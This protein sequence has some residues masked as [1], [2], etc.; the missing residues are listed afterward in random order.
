[1]SGVKCT[2]NS[3]KCL[4]VALVCVLAFSLVGCGS[5]KVDPNAYRIYE[6]SQEYGIIERESANTE[7]LLAERLCIADNT[8]IAVKKADSD[9]AEAGGVF[10]EG[11]KKTV[12]AKDIYARKYPASTTKILTAY[13][14]LKYGKLN[15]VYTVSEN[16][17]DQ[18]YDSTMADLSPGDKISLKELLHG[19][20]MVSGNDAAIA[21]AEGVSGDV[22]SFVKLMNREAKRLGA[23]HS[24]FIN[25]N[26][27][28]HDDHYTCVYDMY[29]IFSAAI[30]KKPFLSILKKPVYTAN[31][32]GADGNP[33]Q[34]LWETTN[35]YLTGEYEVP[36]GITVIGGKTGTT[37]MAGSCLVLLS[38]NARKDPIISVVFHA[39]YR[40]TLFQFMS[41]LLKLAK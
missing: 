38:R 41:E 37:G 5:K 20:L 15:D 26:G 17:C 28:H 36:E 21:I 30:Q 14:A 1:M 9:L 31:F 11:T 3:R 24:H 18:P 32:K 16:A 29:L 22:P 7:V 23:T 13:V 33:K 4:A 40:S 12:Y 2:N 19:M 34:V 25:P 8:N 10:N 35:G 27:L 39:D 6:S